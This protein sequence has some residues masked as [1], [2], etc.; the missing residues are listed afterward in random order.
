MNRSCQEEKRWYHSVFQQHKC[1][2]HILQI[3][4]GVISAVNGMA[5]SSSWDGVGSK[6]VLCSPTKASRKTNHSKQGMY[7]NETGIPR[8]SSLVCIDCTYCAVL[9]SYNLKE[10]I[11]QTPIAYLPIRRSKHNTDSLVLS[12]FQ[13]WHEMPVSGDATW[14]VVGAM[15]FALLSPL[16]LCLL[17]A[18]FITDSPAP[19]VL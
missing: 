11:Q 19:P 3:I 13:A 10:H 7:K 14:Y 18:V 5:H 1:H 8:V 4:C 17:V 15:K 9:Y 16:F 2:R 12:P 6:A